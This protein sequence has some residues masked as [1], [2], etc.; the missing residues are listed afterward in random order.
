M[1][2]TSTLLRRVDLAQVSLR[3]PPT[4]T[5][6]VPFPLPLDP[7][8]AWEEGSN[9]ALWLGPDEWLITDA[10]DTGRDLVTD[11]TQA[12]AG[13]H[14]S[15]IDVGSNRTALELSDPQR[16]EILAAGCA[17]DLHPSRW[18][19]G[20]CAQT[21][22]GKVPVLLHERDASTRV[23]VRPS[24]AGTLSHWLSAARRALVAGR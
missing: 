7:N 17:I 13:V 23:F 2:E 9:A 24:Y 1:A 11:L 21:L 20:S 4:E 8:T 19:T 6:R 14:H 3:L 10:A 18:L 16:L 15:A 22:I 12:L 5:H